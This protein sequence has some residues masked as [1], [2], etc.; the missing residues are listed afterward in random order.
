[1][2]IKTID[3]DAGWAQ[4]KHAG[5]LG[6]E[7]SSEDRGL[8]GGQGALTGGDRDREEDDYYIVSSSS[9]LN[10]SA[11]I[12][13]FDRRKSRSLSF[14][15]PDSCKSLSLGGWWL[16]EH[17]HFLHLHFSFQVLRNDIEVLA[18][19]AEKEIRTHWNMTN[20][21]HVFSRS[22]SH[23]N[24]NVQGPEGANFRDSGDAEEVGKAAASPRQGQTICCWDF[25]VNLKKD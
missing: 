20:R 14:L 24:E 2:V 13:G 16:G 1:M 9:I 18:E 11:F 8:A 23:T 15:F 17:F 10:Y 25:Y 12:W 4:C 3:G 22:P 21:S 7:E 19:E 6:E 5:L